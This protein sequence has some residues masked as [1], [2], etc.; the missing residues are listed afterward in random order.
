LKAGLLRLVVLGRKLYG[1]FGYNSA[2]L[3]QAGLLGLG[4]KLYGRF[5]YNS[6]TLKQ[7]GLLG[8]GK[9]P[10]GALDTTA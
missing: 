3:K 10:Y 8:L 1:R 5:G 6:A 4:R 9:K 7:A 2:M